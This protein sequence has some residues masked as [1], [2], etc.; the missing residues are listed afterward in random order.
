MLKNSTRQAT[1][2][3]LRRKYVACYSCHENVTNCLVE[4]E[5]DR[6]TRICAGKSR[7]KRLLLFCVVLF[8]DPQILF[9]TGHAA[10][11]EASVAVYETR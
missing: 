2:N 7:G 5:F 3:D 9:E 1:S 10:G 11:C 8:E 6:D 4:D